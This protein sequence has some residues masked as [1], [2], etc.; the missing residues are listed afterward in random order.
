MF[1]C[2]KCEKSFK[3][4]SYYL[5]HLSCK[6]NCLKV[7]NIDEKV[8]DINT[9]IEEYDKEIEIK[10]YKSSINEK[11]C[12]FCRKF[13]ANKN[14]LLKHIEKA[15]TEKKNIILNKNALIDEKNNLIKEKNNIINEKHK[16]DKDKERD[17][18]IK[19]LRK[20]IAKLLKKQAP[21]INQ[22]INNTQNNL[23]VIN[24]FGKEDLSH[25]TIQDYKNYLN[26]FFPGFIKYVEK[27]HFDENAPQNHNIYVSNLNSKY[28]SV[29]NGDRWETKV[30][31]DVIDNLLIKKHNQLADKCEHLEETKQI[32]QNIIDNFEEFC[33]S[34]KDK[35]AQKTVKTD[36]MTMLYDNNNK[37][38][39]I[40]KN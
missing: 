37:I 26:G 23:V 16:L 32:E 33:G 20:D 15:C 24:P 18:E 13:F 10:T 35:E 1:V 40:V 21:I 17:N 12:L 36:I 5:R 39:M 28:L 3:Y 6:K 25:I 9:K 11:K 14:N 31:T 30:K 22:T 7:E 8:E 34:F 27:V 29:H 2:E 19:Q 4:K 38:N